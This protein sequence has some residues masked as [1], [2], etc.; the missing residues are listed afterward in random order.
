[1]ENPILST[2]SHIFEQ[3]VL[4]QIKYC[5]LDKMEIKVAL[6][7]NDLKIQRNKWLIENPTHRVNA[8]LDDIHGMIKLHNSQ[9]VSG[10]KDTTI[11]VWD[12]TLSL[13][14][15][16]QAKGSKTYENWITALNPTEKGFI[17]ARRTGE[18]SLFE[19]DR[20]INTWRYKPGFNTKNQ[21]L[22]KDRNKT[23]INCVYQNPY[24]LN[25]FFTGTPHYLQKWNS[26]GR[27]LWHRKAHEH[28]WVYCLDFI[29]ET[30]WIVVIGSTIEIWNQKYNNT[31]TELL[32]KE[33]K[34]EFKKPQR[35]HVSAIK[36]VTFD[37]NL[38]ASALFDGSVKI[39]D[40]DKQQIHASFEE[41]KGRVWAVENL[42][43]DLLASSAD[44][45]S[46]KIWDLRAKNSS[47]TLNNHPGRVSSILRTADYTLLS[48]SCPDNP[49]T[50]DQ[51][52]SLYMWDI[53]YTKESFNK[54]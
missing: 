46:I 49:H 38:L 36:R 47:H 34:I 17:A 16:I 26:E 48:A 11:K 7:L 21:T 28:D 39:I 35:P 2:C 9:L 4:G 29:N 3:S 18:I 15:T 23:R 14:N 6:P 32:L 52:G 13:K 1:M 45:R 20:E 5:P 42:S 12:M 54:N 30:K 19:G 27:M 50:A 8:H 37:T 24:N 22:S 10:S 44:D 25:E 41:H 43:R 40:L 51:K 53:R 31:E 33:D